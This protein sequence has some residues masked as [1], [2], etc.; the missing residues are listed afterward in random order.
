MFVLSKCIA[1]RKGLSTSERGI[2]LGA[3]NMSTPEQKPEFVRSKI[4]QP[5]WFYDELINFEYTN[6]DQARRGSEA[7]H[8]LSAG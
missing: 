8:T 2:F 7:D 3:Q 4:L 5:T 1:V 6:I